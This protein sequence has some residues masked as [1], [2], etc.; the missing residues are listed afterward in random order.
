MNN[1]FAN[2]TFGHRVWEGCV[3]TTLKAG[4]NLYLYKDCTCLAGL[5]TNATVAVGQEEGSPL[6]EPPDGGGWVGGGKPMG[7]G[8]VPF[9]LGQNTLR[10]QQGVK[11]GT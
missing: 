11:L 2:T 9:T 3:L 7:E 5:P 8:I 10:L 4:C 6:A 1:R